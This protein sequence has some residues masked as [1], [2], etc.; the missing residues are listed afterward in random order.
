MPELTD[1]QKEMIIQFQTYQQQLQSILIQKESLRLQIM[2]MDKALEELNAT[3]QEKTYK[4]TGSIMVLKPVA[5]LKK[6]LEEGKE[7]LAVRI[8]SLE[9]TEERINN[10]LKEL[11]EKLREVV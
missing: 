5:E 9:K 8:K 7:A 3:N 10:R 4:I 2:E 1:Q 6:E 11:Q